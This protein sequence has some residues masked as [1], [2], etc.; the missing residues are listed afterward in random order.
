[1]LRGL[2][3]KILKPKNY[4]CN[5]GSIW[6]H[7]EFLFSFFFHFSS[8]ES[9]VRC[10]VMLWWTGMLFVNRWQRSNVQTPPSWW[11][12]GGQLLMR[13]KRRNP[14]CRWVGEIY[15]PVWWSIHS[16]AG[17][18]SLRSFNCE[19]IQLKLLRVEWYLIWNF[20]TF[21]L[22]ETFPPPSIL[23]WIC[24]SSPSKMRIQVMIWWGRNRSRMTSTKA[25]KRNSNLLLRP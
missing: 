12:Y 18:L 8:H 19:P 4:R 3:F 5:T 16:T 24:S 1:M 9:F 25:A 17:Q 6:F 15:K 14:Q 2:H 22:F 20:R 10:C 11:V 21:D 7:V 13:S 23:C